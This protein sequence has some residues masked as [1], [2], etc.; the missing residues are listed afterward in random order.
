ML[1]WTDVYKSGCF[2]AAWGSS[3]KAKKYTLMLA[4][5]SVNCIYIRVSCIL[6]T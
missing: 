4:A 3:C 5:Q 1:I 2:E 6:C